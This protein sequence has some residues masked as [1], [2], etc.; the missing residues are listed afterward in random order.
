MRYGGVRRGTANPRDT[1]GRS[2]FCKRETSW[3]DNHVKAAKNA[4]FSYLPSISHMVT[5]ALFFKA[6]GADSRVFSV[7]SPAG[8]ATAAGLR[9]G[10]V[11]R[12]S[13]QTT[14][15]WLTG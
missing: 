9:A 2:L 5:R 12:L 10:R 14:R 7:L 11:K 13:E 3:C 15:K 6:M 1:S 4:V 8:C